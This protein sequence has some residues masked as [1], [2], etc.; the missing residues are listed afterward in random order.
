MPPIGRQLSF[1]NFFR[2]PDH[3]STLSCDSSIFNVDFKIVLF[4]GIKPGEDKTWRNMCGGGGRWAG[5]HKPD[6]E[7]TSFSF[8]HTPS[9]KTPS[10]AIPKSK[11]GLKSHLAMCPGQRGNKCDEMPAVFNH[12]SQSCF[13]FHLFTC[14]SGVCS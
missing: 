2:D 11:E 13:S 14:S 3:P 1:R 6:L 12:I 4:I 5:V 10:T 8:T 7:V 9:A